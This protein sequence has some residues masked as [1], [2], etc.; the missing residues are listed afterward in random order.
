[1]K[2]MRAIITVIGQDKVGICAKVSTV[3]A[4]HNVNIT[5][6]SQNIFDDVFC[7]VMM[8]ETDKLDINFGEFAELLK[9]EGKTMGLDIR[10][11]HE[12]IFNSMHRI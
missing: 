10:V 11:M 1:M 4:E 12:D 8:T 2:G 9:E 6:V 3:C 5:A 7:M